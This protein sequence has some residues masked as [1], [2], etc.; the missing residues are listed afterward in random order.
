MDMAITLDALI[1]PFSWPRQGFAALTNLGRVEATLRMPTLMA[2]SVSLS[3]LT[4]VGTV[5]GVVSGFGIATNRS[6]RSE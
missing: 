6:C 2:G 5:Q 4:F 1:L 3:G